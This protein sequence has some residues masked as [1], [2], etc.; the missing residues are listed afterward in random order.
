MPAAPAT[1]PRPKIGTRLRSLRRPRRLISR[2]SIDGVA[3][4]VTV[5]KKSASMS[6]TREAA[7]W[8]A[9]PGP[10]RRR[11]PRRP[12]SRRCSTARRW[13]GRVLLDRQR[14]VAPAD[15]DVPVQ[16]LDPVEVEVALLP[17]AAQG[18]E[19]RLLVVVVLRKGR[20]DAGDPRHCALARG[21]HRGPARRRASR[22]PAPREPTRRRDRST[23]APRASCQNGATGRRVRPATAS[24]RSGPR[25]VQAEAPAAR[26]SSHQ[27]GVRPQ[28]SRKRASE[29]E[30]FERPGGQPE[31]DREPF[32]SRDTARR[33][34]RQI[35]SEAEVARAPPSRGR[36]RA[37]AKG[38][39]G[40]GSAAREGDDIAAGQ[41]LTGQS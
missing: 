33:E 28:S 21:A 24:T 23:S 3:M 40:R 26:P 34:R 15:Q 5:T 13:R 25:K 9:P 16:L 17:V 4:P 35:R 36:R 8:R 18:G 12:G 20:A 11:S 14:Q 22:A 19:Q 6:A 27:R 1:Q 30:P 7:R 2:A 38:R 37:A 29:R 39:R 41:S 31:R 32:R 10:P